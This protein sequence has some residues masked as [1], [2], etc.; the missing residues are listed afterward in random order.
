MIM[1]LQQNITKK[2]QIIENATELD[3]IDND[4]REYKIE[5]IYKSTIYIRD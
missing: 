1:A 3:I 4:N 5:A 2:K